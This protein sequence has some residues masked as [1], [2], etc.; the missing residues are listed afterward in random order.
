MPTSRWSRAILVAVAAFI[1]LSITYGNTRSAAVCWLLTLDV[2]VIFGL[3]AVAFVHAL[4][5][6]PSD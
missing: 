6:R 4:R 2:L 1:V 3:L 5:P